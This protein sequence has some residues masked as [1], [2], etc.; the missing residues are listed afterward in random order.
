MISFIMRF[1][2]A[3]KTYFSALSRSCFIS[4]TLSP[5]NLIAS[6]SL[7]RDC[8]GGGEG[9]MSEWHRPLVTTRGRVIDEWVSQSNRERNTTDVWFRFSGSITTE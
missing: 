3:W 7:G 6:S 1:T 4:D 8:D 5:S 9:I 2:S